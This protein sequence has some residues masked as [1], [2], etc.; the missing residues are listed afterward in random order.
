MIDFHTKV[1]KM[2]MSTTGLWILSI[3]CF[4][5]V[6]PIGLVAICATIYITAHERREQKSYD[7]RYKIELTREELDEISLALKSRIEDIT[8]KRDEAHSAEAKD[9]L[10]RMLW[11]CIAA[12]KQTTYVGQ[13]A[14]YQYQ[15]DR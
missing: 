15:E 13:S 3:I 2:R 14:E 12:Q 6:W 1:I 11:T 9:V 4:L 5:F 8:Q 7:G 10:S